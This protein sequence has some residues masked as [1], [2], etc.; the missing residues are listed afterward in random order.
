MGPA[1]TPV[2]K[3]R[4]GR[5]A[6]ARWRGVKRAYR[7]HVAK[8]PHTAVIAALVFCTG[9]LLLAVFPPRHAEKLPGPIAA[10]SDGTPV[11]PAPQLAPAEKSARPAKSAEEAALRSITATFS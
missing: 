4:L 8:Q 11:V 5:V 1:P 2:I 3:F 7:R 10:P 9:A 6:K